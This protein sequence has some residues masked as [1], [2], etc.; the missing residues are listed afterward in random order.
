MRMGTVLLLSLA[1]GAL[2]CAAPD[3]LEDSYKALKEAEGKKDPDALKKA[4]LDTSKLAREAIASKQPEDADEAAHWKQRVE[5]AKEGD[6]YTEY[7]L[8]VGALEP[9]APAKTVDLV[10]TLLS[11]NP[12]SQYLSQCAGAYLVAL[13][14]LGADKQVAGAAKLIAVLPNSEEALFILVNGTRQSP[15]RALGYANRLQTV[16]KSKAKPEGISAADWE[17]KKST[18]LGTANYVAGIIEGEKQMWADCDR[19]LRAALAFVSKDPQS[20]AATYFYLGLA[21]YQLGRMIQDKA[22]LAEA[23]KFSD[24]AAAIKGPYQETAY[25]NSM[26]IKKE[27]GISTVPVQKKK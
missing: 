9:V 14:K 6:T 13:G 10:D 22:K 23:A 12:K 19:N 8:S 20:A 3:E 17:M 18:M 15:D 16:L 2:A 27:A 4:A 1:Y 11:Q 25:K 26:L 24:Q 5:F 7:A 21:N